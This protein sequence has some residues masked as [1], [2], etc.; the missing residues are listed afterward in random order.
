[1]CDE[2]PQHYRKKSRKRFGIESWS[3][4][5]RKWYV[6]RWY[7]TEAQRDQAMRALDKSMCSILRGTDSEPKYRK[8]DR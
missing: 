4:W 5:F 7:E 6:Q 1:M 2:I 8:V 3:H